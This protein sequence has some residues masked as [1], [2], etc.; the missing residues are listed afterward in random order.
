M[1]FF[2]NTW[3]LGAVLVCLLALAACGGTTSGNTTST[4][5][6][7]TTPISSTPMSSNSSTA[8]PG[9]PVAQTAACNGVAKI[10]QALV[11]LSGVTVDTTVGDV[12]AAQ[13]KILNTANSIHSQVPAANGTLLAQITTASAELTAKL[14][15][16][17]NSTTIGHTSETVQDVKT[18]VSNA[19]AKTTQLANNMN[20]KL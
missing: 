19:Q 16:Y 7:S 4:S 18:K 12:R 20:C 8:T 6:K 15:G 11:T 17:P 9:T 5:S 1:R 13:I 10:N 3:K 2:H 14:A